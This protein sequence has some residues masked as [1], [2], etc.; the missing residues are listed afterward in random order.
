[1]KNLKFSREPIIWI[2][3]GIAILMT[4]ADYL[5]GDLSTQSLDALLVAA[6]AVIGRRLV[7]PNNT[8]DETK[9][10]FID[11]IKKLEG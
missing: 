5:N 4:L 3:L 9:E 8:V 11:R 6:G 1:M 10:Y 2:G 7:T